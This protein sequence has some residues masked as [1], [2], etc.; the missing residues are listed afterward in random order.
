MNIGLFLGVNMTF[1]LYNRINSIRPMFKYNYTL[2][3][4][5]L[6][7]FKCNHISPNVISGKCAFNHSC[8]WWLEEWMCCRGRTKGIT[9]LRWLPLLCLCY[10]LLPLCHRWWGNSLSHLRGRGTVRFS[11]FYTCTVSTWNRSVHGLCSFTKRCS[12]WLTCLQLWYANPSSLN[13]AN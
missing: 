8:L 9:H 11:Q 5:G 12:D 6:Q 7:F 4:S 10:T 1:Q 13:N 3:L 2:G